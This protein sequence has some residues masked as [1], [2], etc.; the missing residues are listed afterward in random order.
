VTQERLASAIVEALLAQASGAARVTPASGRRIVLARAPGNHHALGLRIVADAFEMAGWEAQLLKA[1]ASVESL[2]PLLREQQPQ[3]LGLSASL[4][5]HL[6]AM[7]ELL[8]Q[9]RDALG[10]AM[11]RVVVGGLAVNQYPEIA[12]AMGGIVI[13]PDAESMICRLTDLDQAA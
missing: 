10:E 11:P 6:L 5:P 12:R 4:P 3:L 1:P 7:R 13:G 9:L 2:L 8:R